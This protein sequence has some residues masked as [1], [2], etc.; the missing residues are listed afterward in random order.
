MGYLGSIRWCSSLVGM[1]VGDPVVGGREDW[2]AA[3]SVGS[4]VPCCG[5]SIVGNRW[6]SHRALSVRQTSHTVGA[7]AVWAP[8]SWLRVGIIVFDVVVVP[9]Y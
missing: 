9:S 1:S 6:Q 7:L 3:P 4:P 2:L 8:E 5:P